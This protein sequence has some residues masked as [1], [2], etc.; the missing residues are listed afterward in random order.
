MFTEAERF[1]AIELDFKYGRKIAPVVRELGYPSKINLRRWIRLWGSSD[2]ATEAIRCNPRDS[3][4]Q[5]QRAV[6]HY[7][8][9]GCSLA[10]IRQDFSVCFVITMMTAPVLPVGRT[11]NPQ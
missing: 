5:K 2:G 3:D 1:R 6:E 10:F 7:F 8:N 4:E 9:H 11:L